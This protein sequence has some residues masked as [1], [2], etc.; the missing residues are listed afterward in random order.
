M[1]EQVSKG[2]TALRLNNQRAERVTVGGVMFYFKK[3]TIEMEEELD[4]IVKERQDPTLKMPERPADDAGEE[5]FCE[6]A[7]KLI[8]YK[9]RS[10]K[11]FRVLTAEIM[12]YILLDE[13]D[14]PLFAPED[15]VYS[16]LNNVYAENF[17]KAYMQFR[18]GAEASAAQA[19]A[20]FP[21]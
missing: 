15:D 2:I 14:K 4:R 21:K 7:D 11:A 19:E 20:R 13:T 9:Q 1:S 12:K 8:D 17:S 18:F 10:A 16:L 3:L 6:Y 5:A